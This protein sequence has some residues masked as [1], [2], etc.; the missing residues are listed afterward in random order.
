MA[1][2]RDLFH[3]HYFISKLKLKISPFFSFAGDPACSIT[4]PLKAKCTEV[5]STTAAT[6]QD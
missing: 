5:P 2:I 4:K 6:E 1:N 3:V